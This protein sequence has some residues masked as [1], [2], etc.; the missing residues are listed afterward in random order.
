[1]VHAYRTSNFETWE[2]LGVVLKYEYGRGILFRPHVVYSRATRRFVMWFEDRSCEA[3]HCGSYYTA[4]S[5]HPEGPFGNAKAV[6]LP[7]RGSV[8]DFDV[9]VDDDGTGYHVRTGF[10]IVKLTPD[11]TA[12]D[13]LVAHGITAPRASEAPILFRRKQTYYLLVGTGCC[14]C[15]G[16][17]NL[18]VFA[19]Q[20]GVAGP[21]TLQGDVGAAKPEAEWDPHKPDNFVSRAQGSAVFAVDGP[22][23]EAANASFV[24]VGNVWNSG[25]ASAPPGPRNHDLLFWAV[26]GFDDESGGK[27]RQLT[28]QEV[29]TIEMGEC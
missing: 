18:Y 11:L 21:W 3:R 2:D 26:L 28:W 7:G 23:C 22:G 13:E 8:G 20:A 10:D 17:S 6:K 29:V 16:G 12:P 1:M 19:S 14:A 9:F 27:V 5:A 4:T 15:L 24:F 25:L